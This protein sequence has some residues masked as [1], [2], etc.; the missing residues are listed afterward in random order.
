MISGTHMIPRALEITVPEVLK[1]QTVLRQRLKLAV[2][3]P[4][5]I[6]SLETIQMYEQKIRKELDAM[7]WQSYFYA[8]ARYRGYPYVYTSLIHVRIF[9]TTVLY[10]FLYHLAS[11][12]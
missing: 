11:A 7:S 5:S 9:T 3:S 2:S 8:F 12:V 4:A 10:H 1:L 6:I